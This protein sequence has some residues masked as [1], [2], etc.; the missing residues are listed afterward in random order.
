MTAAG[1]HLR[2]RGV[3][4][5]LGKP[6]E[7]S[8]VLPDVVTAL[9]EVGASVVVHVPR[10]GEDLRALPGVLEADVIALR[11]LG[12]AILREAV[13]ALEG[14]GHHRCCNRPSAA[15]AALDRPRLLMILADAG[16]PVPDSEVA[17]DW[18]GVLARSGSPIVAK[19]VDAMA[20]RGA[21]VV[22]AANG[23]LPTTA[24]FAGPYLV[25]EY[26]AGDGADRKLYVVGERT[27]ALRKPRPRDRGPA[28]VFDP[29]P[30]LVGI[31]REAAAATGLELCGIDLIEGPDGPVVVDVNAFPSCKDLPNGARWIGAHLANL[32]MA[33]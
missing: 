22:V 17:T 29:S 5:L 19:A 24:P 10:P 8:P 32:A 21:G 14:T 13:V 30:M 11:G 23:A 15:L 26:V 25:Q 2:G 16:V 33:G 18:Q 27:A 3:A 9:Q 20:G 28:R 6:A 1:R 31:A 12:R 7:R 4:F